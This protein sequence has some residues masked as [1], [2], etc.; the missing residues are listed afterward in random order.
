M[1][2][3]ETEQRKSL[4]KTKLFNKV[5]SFLFAWKILYDLLSLVMLFL[6]I[7]YSFKS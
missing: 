4:G 1:I 5:H 7:I 3:N 6:K 2:R